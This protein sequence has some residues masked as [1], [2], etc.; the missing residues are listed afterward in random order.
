MA[1]YLHPVVEGETEEILHQLLSDGEPYPIQGLDVELVLETPD[2]T[3]IDTS[4]KVTILDDG[5]EPNRGKVKFSPDSDDW[6]RTS[7]GYYWRWVVRD[8]SGKV[9][10]W[11]SGEVMRIK[12][13][14][15]AKP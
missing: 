1:R 15:L 8:G 9:A 5:T 13:F 7:S 12:V 3:P 14:P 2:G 6:T 10:M 11:P 4:T